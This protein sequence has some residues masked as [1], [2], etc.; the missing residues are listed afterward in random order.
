M[1]NCTH[2][3]KA[4]FCLLTVTVAGI[5]PGFSQQ[6]KTGIT[7]ST[8]DYLGFLEYKPKN[9]ATEGNVKHPLIIFLHGIGER[10]NGTTDLKNVARIGLPQ[11]IRDGHPM[12]FTW[13]GKTETF[14]V[15]SPQCPMKYGMWPQAF[16]KDLIAYAKKNL[17][18]DTN[19]IYLT[20]LSM[21]GGGSL[22]YISTSPVA[23]TTVAATATIC[24]PCTFDKGEYV[25][26]A[27]LPLWAFHAADDP[28]ALSSCTDR[29]INR[30]NAANPEVVPI[31]TIWPTGGHAVWDRVY[32]DTNYKFDGRLN[33]YEW[34][35]GQD[36]SLPVNKWPVARTAGTINTTTDV[37]SAKL[38]A[39]ASYDADGRIVRY[40]WKR[41]SGPAV[42]TIADHFGPNSSTTV[43]G[44]KTAGTYQYRL[45]VVDDRSGFTDDTLTIV[46]TSGAAVPNEPPVA[47]AGADIAIKLP[48]SKA[49]LNGSQSSDPEGQPL[50]FSWTK[51]SGPAD[52]KIVSPNSS[53]TEINTLVEGAYTF[54]LRVTDSKGLFSEDDII[55]KV[56]PAANGA[57]VA[58]AGTDITI[59]LPVSTVNLDGSKS[60]DPEGQISSYEWTVV[61][62]PNQ[63][64]IA[65]ASSSTTQVTGLAEGSYI[66]RLKVTDNKGLFSEDDVTVRVSLPPNVLPVS[67]AGN[68]ITITLPTNRARLDGTASSD[69]D[70]NIVSYQ[71]TKI[72]GPAQFII[73]NSN[74]SV[75]DIT[76]LIE[77]SYVFRLRVTDNRGGISDDNIT[78]KVNP[79][80]PPPNAAPVAQAGSDKT[81]ALPTSSVTLNAGAS[82]DPDGNI[83]AYAWSYVSGPAN[84]TITSQNAT[85]TTVTGLEEGV[86]AFRLEVKD[87]DGA[88]NADTVLVKVNAATIPPPTPNLAPVARIEGGDQVIQ[89][90]LNEAG[91]NGSNS[92]DPDGTIVSYTWSKLSGP[93]SYYINNRNASVTTVE[94]LQAGTY[95]FVLQVKDNDGDLARDTIKV[96]VNA[97]ANAA[98]VA[99]AGV[100]MEIEL[101]DPGIR[102]NG[103][104]SSDPDGTI[105]SYSWTQISGAGGITITKSNTTTPGVHGVKPG[106]YIFRLTVVDNAGA[107][108]TDDVKLTVLPARDTVPSDSIPDGNLKYE[109]HMSVYPNPAVADVNLKYTSELIGRARVEIFNMNGMLLYVKTSD[110]PQVQ[111]SQYLNVGG[112][113][114]GI[115]YI[116]I[117]VNGH[118]KTIKFLKK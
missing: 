60:S 45:S 58:K 86:Y 76:N 52:F 70:G 114:K 41:I 26:A 99:D 22:R 91:L 35:L 18:I 115:Y 49:D 69:G 103:L 59:I 25:A 30:I 31:R 68:D 20:G 100:D 11:I 39:S 102:L 73:A 61:S 111:Y 36:K 53:T 112:F 33:I 57:P 66:F 75:T 16:V 56:N 50:S 9:Y 44:L 95:Y 94:N 97:A 24:A 85:V 29:A 63:P 77:G 5:T 109:E 108:S 64:N 96:S 6:I 116:R 87:N 118:K 55:V 106:D 43:T 113:Q 79:A 67:K 82:V 93:S 37:A 40:V 71:W 51:I 12:T 84:Y 14:L 3:L 17:R 28:T 21:G 74:S 38:D 105:Q 88:K 110:K 10:G 101:P 78:V 2:V 117:T 7:A 98:P 15:L 34:F 80:P 46:V 83:V 62:G 4:F 81:I 104:A 19:R 72:T 47:K 89:L 107:S 54:R 65:A 8:G 27:K 90:P 48:V 13:N 42:G 23:P 1:K 32:T 92:S